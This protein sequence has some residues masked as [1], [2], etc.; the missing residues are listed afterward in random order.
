MNPK[1]SAVALPSVVAGLLTSVCVLFQ[2]WLPL[3]AIL[4]GVPMALFF[5]SEPFLALIMWLL[6]SPALGE[7]IRLSLPTGIPDITFDRL[8]V[9][10]ILLAFTFRVMFRGGRLLPAGSI[11]KAMLFFMVV[12]V[13]DVLFRNERKGSE[14]LIV[15]DEYAIPFLLFVA[16]KNLFA[17]DDQVRLFSWGLFVVGVYL[18]V[19]GIRQYLTHGDFTASEEIDP[20]TLGHLLEGRAVGPYANA[21]IYGSV[22]TFAFLWTLYLVSPDR[23]GREKF[24]IGIGLGLI[25]LGVLLSVTRAVWLG[26]L[27]SLFI[28]QLLDRRWRTPFVACL[29]AFILVGSLAWLRRSATS[30]IQERLV[31]ED[32][33]QQRLVSYKLALLMIASRPVFGYGRGQEPFAIGRTEYLAKIQSNWAELGSEIGP[34]H[35]QYLYTL[36]QYGL[37]GFLAHAAVFVAIIRSGVT[38]MRKITNPHSPRRHFAVLFWGMLAAYL[39]QG[40]FADVVAFPFLGALLFVFAGILDRLRVEAVSFRDQNVRV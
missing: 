1:G 8:V 10:C 14:L 22:L 35:N 34:P 20:E 27:V 21:A 2:W 16:A 12:A 17:S 31:A 33:I 30:L 4:V 26:F 38:L 23:V 11:E 19:Y 32:T 40:L 29:V 18:A 7:Y 6:L 13:L 36:V 3:A 5:L 9:G 24:V 28:V 25:G 39:V 37:V 15:F